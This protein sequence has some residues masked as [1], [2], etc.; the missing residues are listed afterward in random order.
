MTEEKA[1]QLAAARERAA[2]AN[3]GNTNS[4]KVNRIMNDTLRRVL[5]QD[6]ALRARTIT[7][8]LV[9]KAEDGDVSAI[10]EVFDRMEGKAVAKTEL[11]GAEGKDL[12]INVVTGINDHD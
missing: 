10:R 11:S 9:A 12:V 3:L 8:A 7:E 5:I 6:E 1:A 4:N 2:E